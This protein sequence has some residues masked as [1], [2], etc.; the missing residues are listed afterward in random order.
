MIDFLLAVPGKLTTIINYLNTNL[1]AARTAR[2]E[3]LDAV[4]SSRAAA[5]TAVS[6]ADYTAARAVLID[7]LS[8]GVPGTVK[9]IQTGYLAPAAAAG[10][11]GEDIYFRDVT[12]TSV[13]V[14]KSIA[15][16]QAARDGAGVYLIET[17]RLTSTT[18]VRLAS[19]NGSSTVGGRWTVVEYF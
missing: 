11:A 4:I 1:A 19:I 6:S 14:A 3:N 12:I 10:G 5:A 15:T 7:R 18:N 13:V 17:A 16:F 8:T 9:S 2:I